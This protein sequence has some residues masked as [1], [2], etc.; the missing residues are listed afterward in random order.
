[1]VFS[2]F[3]KLHEDNVLTVEDHI[4]INKISDHNSEIDDITCMLLG[5]INDD[6]VTKLDINNLIIEVANLTDADRDR[7]ALSKDDH[8]RSPPAP[9]PVRVM[10]GFAEVARGQELA[11]VLALYA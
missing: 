8:R 11:D 6:V 2:V 1:M 9:T 7:S 4:L 5:V 3:D 10:Q